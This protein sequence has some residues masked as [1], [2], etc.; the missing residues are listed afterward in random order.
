M[1]LGVEDA[2]WSVY[3]RPLDGLRRG[4]RA[5]GGEQRRLMRTLPTVAQATARATAR[6]RHARRARAVAARPRLIRPVAP[7]GSRARAAAPSSAGEERAERLRLEQLPAPPVRAGRAVSSPSSVKTRRASAST[8]LALRARAR[9]GS[10]AAPRSP[11]ACR[12]AA[13]RRAAARPSRSSGSPSAGRRRRRGPPRAAGRARTLAERDRAARVAP[14]LADA[15][16]Q[17]LAVAD[18]SRARPRCGGHEERHVRVAEAERRE[19][20]ELLGEPE[21]EILGRRRRRPRP[22]GTWRSSSAS[23]RSACAANASAN[24][25]RRSGSIERP[26]AARWPPNRSRCSEHAPS[27]PWRSKRGDRAARALPAV[28]RARDE[29]DRPVEP[30]DE[31]RG[32]D[33]DHALVPVL[34]P[35]DVAAAPPLPLGKAS[36]SAVASRRIR[37][38]TAWRSRFSSSSSRASASPS[39][40]SSVRMSSSA[41]SGRQSRPAALIR[42][43]SRKPTAPGVDDGGIDARAPHERL[44]PRAA[45]AGERAQPGGRERAV[46]VHERDDVGDRRERDEVEAAPQRRMLGAEKR[47][48]ELVARPR[49]AELGERVRRTASSRRS[50]SRGGV[51]RAVMVGDDDLE[52]ARPRLGDLLDRGDPAVDR[53][54]EPDALVGEPRERVAGHAVALLEAAREVPDDVRAELAEDEHGERGRADAV[55][56]VVAVHA[57]PRPVGDGRA[58]PLDR[59]LPCRR[60]GTGRARAAPRRGSACASSGSP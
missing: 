33:P 59:D 28:L 20:L 25:S 1:P 47:L 43:A 49:P 22:S 3:W 26:A 56:V 17:V 2:H 41:M 57:D 27:A 50:G 60:G 12:T 53:E 13:G 37:S 11:P 45:R 19:A 42:G 6:S 7:A 44:Q 58:D 16:A 8:R 9:R 54:H 23:S 14:L 39:S 31:P 5:R 29:H 10:R 52:P 55:D 34:A 36:T 24:A 32:D 35:E 51:A 46:L 18:E 48:P 15:E 21:R 4:R 38:S 30:L 40:A